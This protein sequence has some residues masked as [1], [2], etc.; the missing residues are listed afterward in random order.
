MS[1]VDSKI[2]IKFTKGTKE[3]TN[4]ET[5]DYKL[6]IPMRFLSSKWK[7]MSG[8]MKAFFSYFIFKIY[9][10]CTMLISQILVLTKEISSTCSM[11][12]YT[13]ARIIDIRGLNEKECFL[14]ELTFYSLFFLVGLTFSKPCTATHPHNIFHAT[15]TKQYS[16]YAQNYSLIYSVPTS[17]NP[18]IVSN[19]ESKRS[20]FLYWERFDVLDFGF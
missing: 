7:R 10:N 13:Y 15:N 16:I 19:D 17:E 20:E 11:Y 9:W 4:D 3:M 8:S 5:R 6:Q 12:M 14:N 1:Y 18:G 2:K